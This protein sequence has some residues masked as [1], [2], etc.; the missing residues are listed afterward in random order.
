[1]Q[2][3]KTYRDQAKG[4]PDLLNWAALV[5]EGVMLGKDG[6][7]TAGWAYM[8]ADV[9][10]AT[11]LERNAASARLNQALASLGSGYMIHVDTNRSITTS[12]P[13]AQSSH[14][15]HPVMQMMD[16]SRR[17]YF[18]SQGDKFATD[19]VLFVTWRPPSKR[20]SKVTDLLFDTND[21]K[22]PSLA[23]R[24]LSLFKDKMAD[25]QGRLSGVFA[26]T[27][28]LGVYEKQE[29]AFDE[30]ME[31]LHYSLTGKKHPISVASTPLPLDSLLGASECWPG[32]QPKI[33][34]LYTSVIS[35]DGFPD[36]SH[37]NMLHH[38][39][40]MNVEFRWNTRFIFFDAHEAH[41]LLDKERKKWKQ[42]S[43]FV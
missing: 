36:F 6:S 12:Y 10:T 37:P 20:L 29:H 19:S 7:F 26:S 2:L 3:L 35:L 15:P 39:S 14:F 41:K 25:L 8:G 33:G 31:Y 40:L 17:L 43:C 38:L 4:L 5:D 9:D 23:Q 42:K 18:E 30:M 32:F 34:D 22:R 21:S 16:E 24:N 28:R 1:M 11:N 27:R 13:A